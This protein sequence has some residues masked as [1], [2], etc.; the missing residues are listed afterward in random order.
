MVGITIGPLLELLQAA[1]GISLAAAHVVRRDQARAPLLQK[2][3]PWAA[4]R[5][6]R[7][8]AAASSKSSGKRSSRLALRLLFRLRKGDRSVRPHWVSR[9]R[10][11]LHDEC[12]PHLGRR[13]G[14]AGHTTPERKPERSKKD[15][16]PETC[17]NERETDAVRLRW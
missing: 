17:H 1:G 2:A 4:L 11:S 6:P 7:R 8:G 14:A 5:A 12:Q 15:S 10:R 13:R 3:I 9:H 16:R